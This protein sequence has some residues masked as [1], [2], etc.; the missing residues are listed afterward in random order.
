MTG[1]IHIDVLL[2]GDPAADPPTPDQ[3]IPVDIDLTG[4]A[5][6]V[7]KKKGPGP[8]E[9]SL[10]V[11]GGS[12]PLDVPGIGT[13]VVTYSTGAASE[14]TGSF[15]TSTGV[16]SFNTDFVVTVDSVDLLGPIAAPCNLG[17]G[18]SLSGQIDTTTGELNVSQDGFAVTPPA[19]SDCGGLGG[20]FAQLLGG[21]DN[22]ASLKFQ[23]GTF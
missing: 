18:M 6:G 17:L 5:T 14:G 11:N 22:S 23:V 16:G 1:N 7:W 2:P 13:L 19:E 10:A 9:V 3:I 20:I 15:D 21:P 8:F 12:F 4:Q